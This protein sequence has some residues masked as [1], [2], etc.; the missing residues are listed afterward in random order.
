MQ[1]HSDSFVVCLQV[2]EVVDELGV[3]EVAALRQEV[4]VVWVAQA[5]HELQLDLRV[6]IMCSYP[7][8]LSAVLLRYVRSLNSEVRTVTMKI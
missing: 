2:G 5:L 1:L 7:N 3:P 6:V 4:E 8:Q